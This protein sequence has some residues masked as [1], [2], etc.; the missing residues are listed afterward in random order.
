VNIRIGIRAVF[1]ATCLFA[2]AATFAAGPAT[3]RKQ[4]EASMLVTG[5]IQVDT[6]G[7]VTGY[8]LD[9]QDK[10]P[11]GVVRL[12][13][14]AVPNW[15]FEPV[16]MD[17]RPVN[18]STDMSIRVVAKKDSEETYSIGIR[19]ASFG[20]NGT[21]PEEQPQ[22]KD[23][24]PPDYP[25]V[26]V[27]AGVTGTVYLLLRVGRDGQVSDA[28]AEQTNLGVVASERVMDG[29]RRRLEDVSIRRSREWKFVPPSQGE[30]ADE[31]FWVVRVP[32]VY[33]L[34][35]PSKEPRYGVWESY[36][37][38][39]R[40]SSPWGDNEGIGFSPDTLAPGAHVAGSG[41]KLV[42]ELSGT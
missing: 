35:R 11:S 19:G 33:S 9:H 31:A 38:G 13:D 29:W 6:A 4:A 42:T 3:V 10:L 25:E 14:Q 7:K 20:D 22:A 27:R 15:T 40:H 34:G 28:I 39:P 12:L 30:S 16:L 2:S 1:A 5:K 23:L 26:A 36:I 8:T 17:G 24:S 37:P 41:L 18:A 32:V 21:R